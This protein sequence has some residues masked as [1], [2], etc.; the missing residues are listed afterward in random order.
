MD[1][2]QSKGAQIVGLVSIIGTLAGFGYTGATYVNRIENLEAKV[3]AL[4]TGENETDDGLDA[5]EQRFAS[6]ETAVE[7]IN[8][9]ID[10]T[11]LLD[12]KG[13]T[14][15]VTEVKV[16]LQK[17]ESTLEALEKIVEKLEDSDKNP[18]AN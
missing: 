17:V 7:F 10:D 5:I 12:V 4:S 6:L 18:L 9:S 13:N 14:E 1:W 11:I 2:L 8:K 3:S 16:D 15:E